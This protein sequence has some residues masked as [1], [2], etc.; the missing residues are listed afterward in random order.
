MH[1]HILVLQAS[2]VARNVTTNELANWPRYKYLRSPDGSFTNPFD[3]GCRTNC[4]ETMYP[5]TV[6][7]APVVLPCEP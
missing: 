6:P 3:R 5:S 2:Q 7:P 1:T 4:L